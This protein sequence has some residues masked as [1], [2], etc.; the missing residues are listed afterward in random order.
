[1][2][3]NDTEMLPSFLKQFIKYIDNNLFLLFPKQRD[4]QIADAVVELFRKSENIDIFN[5]KAL[6]IYIKEI[7]DT[8]TPQITK[9]IKRLKTIYI[10]KYNEFY[11]H[12]DI[13]VN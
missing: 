12:G 6:Y 2:N 8:T 11:K 3:N 10:K 1:V 5:K 7:T 13:D 4:A 9:I